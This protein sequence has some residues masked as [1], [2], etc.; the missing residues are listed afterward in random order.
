MIHRRYLCKHER[1]WLYFFLANAL[2]FNLECSNGPERR[3]TL[4]VKRTAIVV[5]NVCKMN[6]LQYVVRTYWQLAVLACVKP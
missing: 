2:I 1:M 6:V 3:S 4:K 5:I